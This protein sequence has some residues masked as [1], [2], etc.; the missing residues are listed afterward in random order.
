[1]PLSMF[2]AR[3]LSLT[4]SAVAVVVAEIELREIAVQVLLVAVL[5]DAPH[6]A[7]EDR[8]VALDVFVVTSPRRTP[9]GRGSR[10]VL[11]ELLA[12]LPV[13][14]ALIRMQAAG[15]VRHARG[16][17]WRRRRLSRSGIERAGLA[18]ALDQVTIA[19]L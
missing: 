2:V 4:P 6:A 11:G 13:D 16:R 10:P 18:A 19:R 9:F 15:L 7:L 17:S 1:M 12:D 14:A 5:I 8:E 3:S